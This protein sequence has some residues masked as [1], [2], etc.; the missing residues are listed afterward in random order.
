MFARL[1]AKLCLA[2]DSVVYSAAR[3]TDIYSCHCELVTMHVSAL[4]SYLYFEV[5]Y[6]IFGINFE[7]KYFT[8][9]S[10]SQNSH[11]TIGGRY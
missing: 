4:A 6:K 1:I 9:H 7:M 5:G 11:S 8:F 2:S 3:S 10:I